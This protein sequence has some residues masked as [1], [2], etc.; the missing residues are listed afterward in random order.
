[1]T[2]KNASTHRTRSLLAARARQ[3]V[4]ALALA[5]ALNSVAPAAYAAGS[6]PERMTYQGFLV[7]GGGNPLA[8][9]LPANYSVV[10]RIY[11]ASDAGDLLWSEQ[12]V[13]TV[14]KGN[15]SVIL[16]EGAVVNSE[17]RPNLST[18]FASQNASERYLGIT[19]TV[20]GNPVNLLPRLRLLASPYAFLASQAGQLVNPSTGA[21]YI[22]S[23]AGNVNVTGTIVA[24]GGVSGLVPAQVPDLDAAKIVSGTFDDAR[25]S[26]NVPL[27]SGGQLDPAVIPSRLTGNRIFANG[28]GIAGNNVLELGQGLTKQADAGKI[29]YG[30]FTANTLDIVGAGTAGNSRRIKLWAEGGA[31]TSGFLTLNGNT[32]P[33]RPLTIQGSGPSSEWASLKDSSTATIWHVNGVNGGIN[34]SQT[35]VSDGRLFISKDGRIGVNTTSPSAPLDVRGF[36]NVFRSFTYYAPG[37]YVPPF[38]GRDIGNIGQASGTVDY[39]ILADRRIGASEFNAYSDA[40][41][42]DVVGRSESAQDLATINKL[43]VTDYYPIDKIGDGPTLKKGFIAQE[44]EA[45]IPE[46]VGKSRRFIPDIY[47]LPASFEFNSAAQQLTVTLPKKHQLKEGDRVQIFAD[48]NR[49]E[50]A[51]ASVISPE[52]FVLSKCLQKPANVFVFG[53]EVDDFRT[54]NY[55]RIFTTGIG[56]IQELSKLVETKEAR[57]ASLERELASM[58]KLLA[59]QEDNKA[60][61]EARFTALEKRVAAAGGKPAL[62]PATGG[63][64]LADVSDR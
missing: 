5:A 56:A 29:G 38:V 14:D 23:V 7:D 50:L 34:F 64:Q 6:P 61:W 44:V 41:I 19:V 62:S 2:M 22:T 46:A 63:K 58:K 55:D 49:L 24:S 4:L 1:M 20:S 36:A 52:K 54:V 53:K 47:V 15:F 48:E 42:K 30:T 28:I 26:A 43:K 11:T 39:S 9:S 17:P 18:V 16:G 12:Q 21:P 32:P 33:E 60:N 37:S 13:V 31:F 51:V 35:G 59:A 45:V 25:L 8:P 27:L 3:A 57:I 40:R 10:F